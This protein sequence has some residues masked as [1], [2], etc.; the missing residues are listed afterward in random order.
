MGRQDPKSLQLAKAAF[1]DSVVEVRLAGLEALLEMRSTEAQELVAKAAR[2]PNN[3]VLQA[4]YKWFLKNNSIGCKTKA[5][6]QDAL[7]VMDAE[8][9]RLSHLGTGTDTEHDLDF[10]ALEAAINVYLVPEASRARDAKG[11]IQRLKAF[12][13]KAKA[14]TGFVSEAERAAESENLVQKY[15]TFLDKAL[16]GYDVAKT[17]A[18]PQT[19][20][21]YAYYSPLS[22]LDSRP[23]IFSI[24]GTQGY[25]DVLADLNLGVSQRQSP[26]F[27]EMVAMVAADVRNGKDVLITG[28]SLGG[29]LAQAFAYDVQ[30]MLQGVEHAGTVRM[31]SWNAFGAKELIERTGTFDQK[32]ADQ[33]IGVNY[34]VPGDVVSQIGTPIGKQ[35]GTHRAPTLVPSSAEESPLEL[36][37]CQH[38]PWGRPRGRQG[39]HA[40]ADSSG[41][42]PF[43]YLRRIGDT[44]QSLHWQL[45]KK[46][47]LRLLF[48]THEKWVTEED[49]KE[50]DKAYRWLEDEINNYGG[51]EKTAKLKRQI[52]EHMKKIQKIYDEKRSSTSSPP[53][54]DGT[55]GP[56]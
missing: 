12:F 4:L 38:H 28:H 47:Y 15:K 53:P 30:A 19:G 40:E 31:T 13:A 23:R 50:L 21:K 39:K 17:Y 41:D 49:W 34:Y 42:D 54:S 27:K 18:D 6:L 22:H 43:Q 44:I 36:C 26:A 5:L 56:K 24:G 51:P 29:G 35:V 20:L 52:E 3:R 16:T 14:L 2:D 55:D 10:Q 11:V 46:Q 25:S 1:E 33:I 37:E 45:A 48:D 8:D 7:K 32:I 9:N